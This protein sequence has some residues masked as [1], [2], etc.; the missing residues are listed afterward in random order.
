MN[1]FPELA[2]RSYSPEYCSGKP[3]RG[4]QENICDAVF[5]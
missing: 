4:S 3:P 5:F 2:V 1:D